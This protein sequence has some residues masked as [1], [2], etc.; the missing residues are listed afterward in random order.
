MRRALILIPLLLFI[1][2][3]VFFVSLVGSEAP[4]APGSTDA[5]ESTEA[6]PQKGEKMLSLGII[7]GNNMVP[8][9]I[10]LEEGDRVYLRITSDHPVELHI[11]G[12][13]LEEELEPGKTEELSFDATITGR[14]ELE[15]H[16][17]DAVLGVLFV[18]PRE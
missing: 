2:A 15:D 4:P 12:Y 18:W 16:E 14:F 17:A 6:P 9:T 11:H 5:F 10:T 1:W 3:T 7:E 8:N 13:D